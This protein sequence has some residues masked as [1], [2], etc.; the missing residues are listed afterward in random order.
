[1]IKS[2]PKSKKIKENLEKSNKQKRKVAMQNIL[3][4]L[5]ELE[6]TYYLSPKLTETQ[7]KL[8]LQKFENILRNSGYPDY[9]K[10]IVKR[11]GS[12]YL[13]DPVI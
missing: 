4:R 13:V 2:T 11:N 9:T 3:E 10:S 5:K 8:L 1:M 6:L 12:Y 7:I